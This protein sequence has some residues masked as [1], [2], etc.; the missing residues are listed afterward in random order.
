MKPLKPMLVVLLV[1][2]FAYASPAVI[3]NGGLGLPHTKAAWVSQTGRL[4]M[5]THT[6]FWGQVH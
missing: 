3:I 5:L 4:T 6:R 2:L 1:L